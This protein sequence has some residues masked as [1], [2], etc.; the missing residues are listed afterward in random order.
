MRA[1]Q[2]RVNKVF[3][4]PVPETVAHLKDRFMGCPF[5]I[6]WDSL[7]LE[8][9]SS[10]GP[11]DLKPNSTYFALPG[12]M[13]VWYDTPTGHAHLLLPLFPSDKMA[14]RHAAIGDAWSLPQFRPVLS[15][16]IAPTLRRHNRAFINSVATGMIDT[17]PV[18]GFT[19]EMVVESES[20]FQSFGDFYRDYVG[21][22]P[23][24]NQV[25]LEQDEGIE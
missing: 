19:G 7:G 22:G 12:G 14:R 4:L 6:D 15:F 3:V 10:L 1:A 2:G 21:R 25:L 5:D 8:I 9:G 13:D 23:V 20:E 11:I 18:L 17:S 16:G 24:S